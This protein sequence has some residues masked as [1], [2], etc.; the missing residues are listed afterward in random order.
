MSISS[1][2]PGGCQRVCFSWIP[3]REG[4]KEAGCKAFLDEPRPRRRQR[5]RTVAASSSGGREI[6]YP[7]RTHTTSWEQIRHD[8][9]VRNVVDPDGFAIY[10]NGTEV[11]DLAFVPND[12]DSV[13][14][15]WRSRDAR[16]SNQRTRA[17]LSPFRRRHPSPSLDS[18]VVEDETVHALHERNGGYW[19]LPIHLLD[20]HAHA[21]DEV[22]G[23][24]LEHAL[25]RC[26]PSVFGTSNR[27]ILAAH[28]QICRP[29]QIVSP[30]VELDGDLQ[31]LSHGYGPAL[32]PDARPSSSRPFQPPERARP[33]PGDGNRMTGLPS[34]V[35]TFE[36]I[37]QER[38]SDQCGGRSPLRIS[39]RH[40]RFAMIGGARPTIVVVS[41]PAQMMTPGQIQSV[42]RAQYRELIGTHGIIFVTESGNILNANE[43]Y[44]LSTQDAW[45]AVLV[46]VCGAAFQSDEMMVTQ[47]AKDLGGPLKGRLRTNQ[48]KLLLRGEQG[49]YNRV[50]KARFDPLKQVTLLLDAASRYNMTIQPAKRES[51]EKKV[52]EELPEWS[53]VQHGKA[54]PRLSEHKVVDKKKLQSTKETDKS[55]IAGR[56]PKRT[57]SLQAQDWTQ[58]IMQTF[59]WAPGVYLQTS[60]EDASKHARLLCGSKHAVAIVC[61]CVCIELCQ[62]VERVTFVLSE[63]Q[64][65]APVKQKVVMGYLHNFGPTQVRY[66]RAVG[67]VKSQRQPTPTVALRAR[68]ASHLLDMST[69]KH[70]KT[71]T[72]P[73][74]VRKYLKQAREELIV[75]DVFRLEKQD[76]EISY[77]LRV[78][79]LYGLEHSISISRSHR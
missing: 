79:Q 1:S 26:Y 22:T 25:L 6:H 59:S 12:V 23:A 8:V 64:G 7:V 63:Q 56:S 39:P 38:Y 68:I 47:L 61:V 15:R 36:A 76:K 66:Q 74:E 2:M 65:D 19:R 44:H 14:L 40:L 52:R 17:S 31:M 4:V 3:K 20:L 58:P 29:N 69:W 54:K 13:E 27:V 45:W 75:E 35:E 37:R 16:G 46:P 24:M 10:N 72:L 60:V 55:V 71:L 48:V 67:V 41:I 34:M 70:L 53:T 11:R 33:T 28:N 30:W 42:M 9:A 21:W 18:A 5:E 78:H 73:A 50:H 57:L 77:L 43:L 49:L 62:Q 32:A 51:G